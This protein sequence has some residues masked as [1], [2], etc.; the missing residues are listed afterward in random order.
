MHVLILEAVLDADN[1][2]KLEHI[3]YSTNPRKLVTVADMLE[4][5]ENIERL[6]KRVSEVMGA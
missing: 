6:T 2:S 4:R 5:H 1:C 3:E